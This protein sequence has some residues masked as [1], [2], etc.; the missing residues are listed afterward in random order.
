[1]NGGATSAETSRKLH[2]N[3]IQTA[4]GGMTI[5]NN[6]FSPE[7]IVIDCYSRGNASPAPVIGSKARVSYLTDDGLI[8]QIAGDA[9]ATVMTDERRKFIST[10]QT[11]YRKS[12]RGEGIGSCKTPFGKRR[13]R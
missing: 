7:S 10:A 3:Y 4:A 13:F 11:I 5:S 8:N 1:M 6:T 12:I 9:S 2:F